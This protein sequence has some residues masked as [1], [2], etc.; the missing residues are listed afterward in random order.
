MCL[1]LNQTRML[2]QSNL[3]T[4]S[5]LQPSGQSIVI[6]YNSNYYYYYDNYTII[7]QSF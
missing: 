2:A 1:L 7:Y 5:F 4:T 6:T 3:Q